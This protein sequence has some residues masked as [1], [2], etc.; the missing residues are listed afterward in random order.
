MTFQSF[1]LFAQILDT[2]KSQGIETPTPIQLMAISPLLEGRDI[3]ACAPTGTGKT[4]A[5]LLPALHKL[6]TTT[7]KSSK[8]P[9]ILILVPTR[10]LATQVSQEAIKFSQGLRRVKTICIYGGMPY[11]LQ[12][13]ML[14]RPYEILVA[15]PGRLIDWIERGEIEFDRLDMLV[16]DEADRMLDM[17][18]ADDIEKIVQSI[19]PDRQTVLFSATLKGKIL[20]LSRSLLS[21]P[22]QISTPDEKQSLDKIEQHLYV[23]DDLHHK[24]RLIEHLFR[25][26]EMGSTIIFTATKAHA[27][28][29]SDELNDLGLS[30]SP[31][32]GDMPQRKREHTLKQLRSRAIQILVATD[33]AARGVHI[34][35]I[36]H[37]INF[38]LPM[39]IEDYVH[40]IGRTGRAGASGRAIS[41]V[42]KREFAL[43]RRI[44]KYTGQAL[45]EK[46]IKGLESRTKYFRDRD[47][48]DKNDFGKDR[49]HHRSRKI[50]NHSRKSSKSGFKFGSK[51][52]GSKASR[53]RKTSK[54]SHNFF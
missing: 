31:L 52:T 53:P 25:E 4:L 44:E 13:R 33:V 16:F 9:R 22:L 32:H 3:Q 12:R 28:R 51:P 23:T 37:V 14:S 42:S 40:R 36:E 24:N 50:P 18:F 54:S 30:A 21:N 8:G 6:A 27:D 34:Q 26:T 47:S 17:G 35:D 1:P 45:I 5:F 39:Q 48:N 11:P 7:V 43:L 29:L 41:L 49:H 20:D 46:S 10:E 19:G 15:T 2:L 38:D